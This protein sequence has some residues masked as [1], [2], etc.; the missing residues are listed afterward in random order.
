MS[1]HIGSGELG[2]VATGTTTS[3]LMC[4]KCLL[5]TN[6]WQWLTMPRIFLWQFH[7]IWPGEQPHCL[8]LLWQ[9][10][11]QGRLTLCMR[12]FITWALN[13]HFGRRCFCSL[14]KSSRMC[15]LCSYFDLLRCYPNRR[16][17]SLTHAL[18][19]PRYGGKYELYSSEQKASAET[20]TDQK[21]S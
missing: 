6:L 10:N 17:H 16:T 14:P 15:S 11:P 18:R 3:M 1:S 20:R 8:H 13:W 5:D 4:S 7:C 12:K 21:V 2:S 9:R 19:Y